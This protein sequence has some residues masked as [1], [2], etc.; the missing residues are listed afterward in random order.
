MFDQGDHFR[1]G[2]IKLICKDHVPFHAVPLATRAKEIE[3]VGQEKILKQIFNEFAVANSL[4]VAR[5]DWDKWRDVLYTRKDE[6]SSPALALG[7]SHSAASERHSL[8]AAHA[9]FVASIDHIGPSLNLN[10]WAYNGNSVYM[11]IDRW[12]ATEIRA[13][14]AYTGDRDRIS[15]KE[16]LEIA[17]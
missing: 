17:L 12:R 7:G 15:D 13:T 14:R 1:E 6:H 4:D 9:L 16:W 10:A 3:F 5:D 8:I 2:D 11:L